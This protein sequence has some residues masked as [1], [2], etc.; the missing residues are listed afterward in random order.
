MQSADLFSRK[1]QAYNKYIESKRG[2]KKKG[3]K[4][5]GKKKKKGR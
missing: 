1:L 3:K 5:G 4:G 2:K